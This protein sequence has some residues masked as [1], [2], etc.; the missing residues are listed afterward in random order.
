[1]VYLSGK[2]NS[3]E[4]LAPLNFQDAGL[5]D[6]DLRKAYSVLN[7][8]G[9]LFNDCNFL[10][11]NDPLTYDYLMGSLAKF[12]DEILKRL[13]ITK[14]H[15][16]VVS[17][18]L[19][20]NITTIRILGH[21]SA[22]DIQFKDIN[23]KKVYKY[24]SFAPYSRNIARSDRITAYTDK[25]GNGIYI[26]FAD[27]FF[28]RY[29]D[30]NSIYTL[31]KGSVYYIEPDFAIV[32]N[33]SKF[34]GYSYNECTQSTYLEFKTDENTLFTHNFN[35]TNYEYINENMLDKTVFIICDKEGNTKYFNLS[36]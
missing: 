26:K 13:E 24:G 15:G 8:N 9:K 3:N 16:D 5:L 25:S 36:E 29:K 11:P 2:C 32:K 19:E 17:V 31:Y 23:S 10:N 4:V 1:V 33:V 7:A 20:K 6:K 18:S 30:L 34:D 21:F 14:E 27:E 22:S 35:P 28:E 12:E